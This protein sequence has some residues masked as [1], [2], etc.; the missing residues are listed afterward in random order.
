MPNL[1]ARPQK[2]GVT[3]YYFDT[4]GK[5]RKEIPLGKDY[6]AAVKK[7]AELSA[8]ENVVVETFEALSNRFEMEWIPTLSKNT[9]RVYRS[10]LKHLRM[11]FK[12]A[13]L[14]EIQPT[15][16]AQLLDWKKAQPT[17]ANRLKRMTSVM[18]NK[19]RGWGYLHTPN[20]VIGIEGLKIKIV[21]RN[22]R[23]DVFRAIWEH[24]SPSLRDAMDLA[25]LAGQRPADTLKT[26]E[27]DIKANVLSIIQ[28]KGDGEVIVRIQ[29]EGELEA[30][31]NRINER[32]SHFKVSCFNLIVNAHGLPLTMAVVRKN[33]VKAKKAAMAANPELSEEIKKFWFTK[34]RSKA[35]TD[36]SKMRGDQEASDLLG[37]SDVQITRKHY[38][39]KEG[40]LVKPT[41]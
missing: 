6:I 31:I 38:I 35:A 3:Y 36:V 25:Y 12:G 19:A 4:G 32:K 24:S 14:I 11:F 20:P 13:P 5:P 33:L 34:L 28:N 29:I 26:S 27:C 16:I 2:S 41:R 7:W 40:K 21:K 18:L 23:T 37:H 17:T 15:H 9:Q 30:L 10:D 1:R 39:E 8:K 22:I